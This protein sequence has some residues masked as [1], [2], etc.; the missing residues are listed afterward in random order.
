MR[1]FGITTLLMGLLLAA[2]LTNAQNS[3][4]PNHDGTLRRLRVPILMYH[5]ISNLPTDA[6][7]FRVELTVEPDI[8]R[9]HMQHLAD[10]GYTPITLYDLDAALLNGE[11]L[12]AKPVVLTF[13][14]GHLDHY[15]DA[16]PI[17]QAFSFSGTFFVIT[18]LLDTNHPDYINWQQAQEMAAAGHSIEPHTK[19]HMD[20]RE[21]DWDFLVYQIVGS[22]ESIEANLGSRPLMFSY[23]GGKYDSQTLQIAQQADIARAVTT[24]L[25]TVHTTS[26]RLEVSRVRVSGNLSV[27]G[28]EYLLTSF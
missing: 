9:A 13:D 28:L 22:I 7:E 24:Q 16:F 18:S 1:I 5:Y 3:T 6:D 27:A 26:N 4:P 10:A 19:N 21:R 12:P 20:L 25:G 17:L 11:T 15:T 14:D 8:F 2:N 23:P